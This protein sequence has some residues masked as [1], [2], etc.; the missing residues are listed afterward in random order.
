MSHTAKEIRW[1]DQQS[2]AIETRDK[3]LLISAAAGSGKTATLTERI[4]RRITE[5]GI[6]ISNMLIVTF[7]RAAA[8][9]LR[10]KIFNAIS[11]SLATAENSE[12]ASMLS[13]QLAKLNNAKICTIDSFYY[14]LVKS[15]FSAADVSPTF[16]IIDEG[17][18]K[19]IAKRTMNEVIDEFY[20]NESTFP[21]F[22]ECFT[23]IRSL[24]SLCDTF[25][26]IYSSL[27]SNTEGIEYLNSQAKKLTNQASLD[28]LQTDYG[29]L[30][31]VCSAELFTHYKKIF[32]HATREAS[33]DE[34]I[35]KSYGESIAI[36][37][38]LCESVLSMLQGDSATYA[39]IKHLLESFTPKKMG[40]IKSELATDA[41]LLIKETR[42]DFH[43]KRKK[44]YEKYYLST[45]ETISRAMTETAKYVEI[46]YRLLK[47]FDER[48]TEQKKRLD[49]LTF[50]DISRK[51]YSL[52]VKNSQPTEI[53]KK[54][55]YEYTDIYIDEYQDVDPLQNEIFASISTPTNLFMVGDIK[56]SIYKFR[57]AEPTLFSALRNKFPDIASAE[58]SSF[59]T[60]FMSNNFRCDENI[61]KFT[62]L[63][64]SDIF[65]NAGGCVKYQDGDD[66]VFSKKDITDEYLSE[67]VSVSVISIPQSRHSPDG[68]DD[69]EEYIAMEWESEHIA[70]QI[71]NLIGK[72]KKANGSFITAGDIAILFRNKKMS[73]YLSSALKRRGIKSAETEATQY[74]ENDDVLMMLCVLNTIDNPERDIYLAGTLRS[75][76][77]DFS[78]DELLTLRREYT[79]PYSLFGGLCAY[80]NE[81]ND[82]LSKKCRVFYDELIFWQENSRALSIDRF[83]LMLFNTDR[84][85]ASG[86]L[87]TQSSD[88]DGGN[89]LLL[90]DYAR[91]FQG[92]SFKGLYEFIEYVNSLIEEGQSFPATSKRDAPDRV[93]LMTIHKSKGLEFPVCFL[94]TAGKRFS[95]EEAKQSF[96]MSYPH[97][98]AMKLADESGFALVKTPMRE[99]LLSKI[100]QENAEEEIRVLY[101]ALTRARERLYVVGTS[102]SSEDTLLRKAHVNQKFTD[103][104]TVLSACSSYLDWI[105]LALQAKKPDYVNLDFLTPADISLALER[106]ERENE[107]YIDIDEALYDDLTRSFNFE[108]AY[109]SLSK[110]PSKLSVSRL[111][112]DVLDEND[113]SLELFANSRQARIPEFFS[114]DVSRSSAA[115]RGT[116]THLFLQFCSFEYMA[117]HSVKEELARLCELKY[118]PS[119]A[120][121]LIYIDELER[122]TQSE[123]LVEILSAKRIIREQRFNITLPT[124]NFT[125][126]SALLS[127]MQGE[128][129]AVQGVIDLI[130]ITR[131]GKI[132]LYDYKTD[133]LS[134][135][136]LADPAIAKAMLESSHAN[137]LSY[138]AKAVEQMFGRSCDS[139]QIYSTHASRLYDIDIPREVVTI[140]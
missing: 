42:S 100:F 17:E 56:Q 136:A 45:P 98:V 52:L 50:N 116:A 38:K 20:E 44:H 134:R 54:L 28:L 105:L 63:I 135:E 61:V 97:G 89:V 11:A 7:T 123:L 95:N 78:A 129:L 29:K 71:E 69:E 87:S 26:K 73:P 58:S 104:Y 137:Q 65:K 53:A 118:L 9:D 18:Y 106:D 10:L 32:E 91:S 79:E 133:R 14:D 81:K 75:P 48:M 22:V 68:A 109:G 84:F 51:T 40:S 39:D 90:Y 139:I 117:T 24:S 19:L 77:F 21:L 124:E 99:I 15:N 103:G 43:E 47:A 25:L 72:K 115:E 82:A 127:K 122:F 60:V 57:G 70:S 16:R 121:S 30:L 27:S 67:N 3:T 131:D 112:P 94:S 74:F 36:D 66:L 111:Y 8:A 114:K 49:F 13:N 80:M 107:Q 4:I 128:A 126:N 92:K 62:N 113:T 35:Q 108:Y 23:T 138:Y 88:G 46:L 34:N 132:K 140:I 96:I 130:I 33:A 55:S 64:C 76:L 12:K 101:V 59:A 85:V 93:S 102:K 5:D 83:L 86:I 2:T 125:K 1:T 37:L 120:Q 119:N 31:K 110:V 6:D 41:S